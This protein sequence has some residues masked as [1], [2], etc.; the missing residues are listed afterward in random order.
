M[1]N[2]EIILQKLENKL[3]DLSVEATQLAEQQQ[4]LK[5]T[6]SSVETR[7]TQIVGAIEA[8]DAVIKDIQE[9]ENSPAK[10]SAE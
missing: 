4:T 7:L 1:N 10:P 2:Y 5:A 3:E 8:I 9:W 6:M